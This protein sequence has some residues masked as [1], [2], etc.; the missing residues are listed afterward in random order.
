MHISETLDTIKTNYSEQLYPS[1][2]QLGSLMINFHVGSDMKELKFFRTW[3]EAIIGTRSHKVAYRDSITMGTL[4]INQLDRKNRVRYVDEY[5]DVYP[6]VITE[7]ALDYGSTNAILK[8]PVTFAYRVKRLN[9]K[10]EELPI[11]ETGGVAPKNSGVI[12]QRAGGDSLLDFRVARN[13]Q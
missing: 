2:K 1:T 12:A 8:L 11:Q 10:V 7:M 4:T 3:M 6:T 5:Q 13:S 9:V